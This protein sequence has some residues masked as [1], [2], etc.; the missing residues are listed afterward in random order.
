M[1]TYTIVLASAS[2]RRKDLL[3][4]LGIYPV[5]IPADIDETPHHGESP[6]A[7][8]SRM[9]KEKAYAIGRA[10]LENRVSGHDRPPH[11]F[12]VVG[13]DTVVDLD[14][15]IFGKP[16][17]DNDARRM[18]RALSGR[19]HRVHT[20]VVVV[21]GTGEAFHGLVTSLVTMV[22]ITDQLLEW[23]IATGE[24]HDKAGSY[25][26]QGQGGVLVDKVQGPMS[27][28]VGLP[29]AETVGLLNR[30]GCTVV[31]APNRD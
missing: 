4:Q 15:Q 12:G 5:I 8:A 9:A 31:A 29:L 19:T 13:A 18:L 25:A 11:P 28:V 2:P 30:A 23:Y 17:D 21:A 6:I 1:S 14:G 24:P 16:V 27:N 22:P 3:Q 7:F 26:V 20:A 10:V